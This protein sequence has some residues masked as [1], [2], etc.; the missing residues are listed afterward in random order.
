MKFIVD[1]QQWY[2]G[3]GTKASRLLRPDGKRCCIGFVGQQCGVPDNQL[4]RAAINHEV[5]VPGEEKVAENWPAW[6]CSPFSND[7]SHVYDAYFVNDDSMIDDEAREQE[8]KRIFSENGDE[9]EF[10]N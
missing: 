10:I 9:I 1:R 2:R 3:K 5:P 4:Q 6:M 7:T 8:L